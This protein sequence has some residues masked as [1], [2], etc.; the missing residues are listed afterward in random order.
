MSF[1][2]GGKRGWAGGGGGR[3]L[4]GEGR[5]GW[6]VG[7]VALNFKLC[8]ISDSPQSQTSDPMVFLILFLFFCLRVC[9]RRGGVGG[10]QSRNFHLFPVKY[11]LEE[12]REHLDQ[13]PLQ[14]SGQKYENSN[15][16]IPFFIEMR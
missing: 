13:N 14:K 6:F 4:R 12:R 11:N 5:G 16:M 1:G 9:S 15:S 8:Q 2:G 3:T 10:G 7:A